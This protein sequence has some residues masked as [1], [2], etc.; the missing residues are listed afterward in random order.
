MLGASV[1]TPQAQA[2]I[3]ADADAARYAALGNYYQDGI[4]RRIDADAARYAALGNY[5]QD[6]IQRGID[7]DA[8]RYAALGRY[9]ADSVLVANLE[10][11]AARR[12][13][14]TAAQASPPS[15][16]QYTDVAKFYA[17]RMRVQ[18]SQASDLPYTDVAKFYAE[19]MRV[20]ASQSGDLAANPELMI[21]RRSYDQGTFSC[22]PGDE[23]LAVNPELRFFYRAGGC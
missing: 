7:A 21:A 18:A 13:S 17:E 1:V 11:M 20:Q 3:D 19:R 2:S 10:L 14:S 6:G 9:Y 23:V 16:S 15:D 12:Y 8:A 22:S 5:Y 4:Q